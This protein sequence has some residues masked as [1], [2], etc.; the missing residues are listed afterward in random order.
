MLPILARLRVIFGPYGCVQFMHCSTGRGASGRRVLSAIA[1]AL[2][3][4]VS[5]GVRDQLGGGL[6]TFRFEGP[7]VTM[8]PA[9]G[10]VATWA[11]SRADFVPATVP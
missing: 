11:S 7:T 1:N 2:G 4:P 5:A 10:S 9:G 8:L 3:V 6:N